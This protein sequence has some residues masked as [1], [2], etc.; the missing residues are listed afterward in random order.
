MTFFLVIWLVLVAAAGGLAIGTLW[1]RLPPRGSCATSASCAARC[2][3]CT[4]NPELRRE[5]SG[6]AP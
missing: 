4:H 5:A 1:G 2:A 6:S 3:G